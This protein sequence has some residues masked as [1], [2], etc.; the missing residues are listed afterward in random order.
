MSA[1]KFQCPP[2]KLFEPDYHPQKTIIVG[3]DDRLESP[4]TLTLRYEEAARAANGGD[5]RGDSPPRLLEMATYT[6]AQLPSMHAGYDST[7][8][9][10]ASYEQYQAQS[11]PTQQQTEKFAQLNQQNFASNNAAVPQYMPAGPTVL[12]CQPT[13]G[14]VGT[15]IFIKLSSQ[16][17]LFSLSSP[18]PIWFLLFG[19]EKCTAQ[20]VSRDV[21]DSSGF[22]YTCSGEAPQF[23]VT[24]CAN[25]NVPLSLLLEG[26]S[27]EE[28]SRTVVG[29]F[30][31]YEGSG[32]DITR[33]TKI[34]K[35]E[36]A[37]PAP[38]VDQPSTSPK[39]GEPQL[40]SEAPTNTYEYPTQQGQYGNTFAQGNNDMLSTYRST[41]FTD[42]HYHRRPSAWSPYPSTLGSTGRNSAAGLDPTMTGRPN[43]TPLPIPS[44]S[45]S[46]TPQL[47]RTSTIANSA[48]SNSS[49]HP[50]S[51][52]SSKAVL[53]IAGKLETMAENWTQEEWE[54]R[55]RIVLFRKTQR[56][57][58]LNATFQ[59]VGVQDRPPNSVCISCIWWAEK[60]E[61]YVTS[62]DTIYLLEQLVAA[63]NRFSVEEKN[64]IRRNL[65]G[66]HPQTVSKAKAESEEFFKIIMAFPNPKPRN[67]EKDVK[68]FP[69]K[70]LES[71]LKKIIGKYSASPSSTLPPANIMNQPS[72]PYAPLP[73]P[74]GPSMASHTD[75]HQQYSLPQHHDSI[76]SPR[77]LSGSQ[78]SWTP[79]AAAPGYSTTT[80]RTLSPGLRHSSPQQPQPPLRITTTPLPAVSTYDSRSGGYGA[81]GLHTPISHHPPAA[82]PPRW[83][84][85]PATYPESYPSLT[86]QTAQPVYS[87]GGYGEPAPRA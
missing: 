68:V 56:G 20:D 79:Y 80:S 45:Q 50:I 31:Y 58:T 18:M 12:S 14:M 35:H 7:R 84:P 54:N 51:L 44:S 43:L 87:A 6:K 85:T 27:G 70:I 78:P 32:D 19:S 16:Y 67:I 26:P 82:T 24:G 75:P 25:S 17:D 2:Y 53:K 71:A 52:Y 63:P 9:Q 15:K 86:S 34:P 65:E 77:S 62:V 37:A 60:N 66:F 57:S 40:P 4:D 21:Q 28:I 39:A 72:A 74:P 11:F 69:W 55:R 41:S 3:V 36:D 29:T 13:T 33:P 64:R 59:P 1:V 81:T 22:L 76:P 48:G 30:Q 5:P 49:Y 38:A 23:L 10:D 73:T 42:P 47:I 46:G 83:D 8:Y 61:C